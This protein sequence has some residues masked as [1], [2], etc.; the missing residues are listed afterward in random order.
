MAK[1]DTPVVQRSRPARL[2]DRRLAVPREP[3]FFDARRSSARLRQCATASCR[4]PPT[5]PTRC[6]SPPTST[7]RCSIDRLDGYRLNSRPAAAG[8]R[9]EGSASRRS[10]AT[11]GQRLRR[12][13]H[14]LPLGPSTATR[15]FCATH[16]GGAARRRACGAACAVEGLFFDQARDS[17][18]RRCAYYAH[19][20]AWNE[21]GFGGPASPRGY[22]RMDKNRR[23]P[24]EAAEA[25]PGG[26]GRA[27][28]GEPACRLTPSQ[29]RA[30]RTGAPPTSS[31]K[32]LG[33]DEPAP[34]RR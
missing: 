16:A 18:H 21:M 33:R 24:W 9:L 25:E 2:L 17:R 23:D 8:R 34:R 11:H 28:R 13:F 12:R 7:R 22:V 31:R 3:R 20:T 26:E 6:R 30:P 4:S 14:L 29:P 27:L 32:A 10:T 19:P 15:C 1:R 5:A